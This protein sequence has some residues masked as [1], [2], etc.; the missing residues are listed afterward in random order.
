MEEPTSQAQG[1]LY[2]SPYAQ[3]YTAKTQPRDAQGRFRDVLARLKQDLGE[4]SLDKVASKVAEV[5]NLDNAGDYSRAAA[6]AQE[7]IDVVNRIDTKALN[8]Q[9]LESVRMGASALAEAIANLPLPFKNQAQKIR[10]SD[11]PPSLQKLMDDMMDKVE[12]K[13]G[14]EDAK[15]ATEHLRAFKSGSELF[16]QGEIS[17]EMNKLLRLLT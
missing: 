7:V 9:A 2:I 12:Q 14:S 11:V 1:D 3:K 4:A 6:G 17:S 16:S 8:P 13:I 15:I 10:Y 5:E